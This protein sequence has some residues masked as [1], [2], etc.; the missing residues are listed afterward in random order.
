VYSYLERNRFRHGRLGEPV[1]HRIIL[2]WVLTKGTAKSAHIS[3]HKGNF[4][5]KM[6]PDLSKKVQKFWKLEELLVKRLLSSEE[7]YCK[8]LFEAAHSGDSSEHYIVFR[9]KK[10]CYHI[11]ANHAMMR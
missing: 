3:G 4:H 7:T 10:K 9:Q 2:E 6:E 5:I 8:E 11:W 1:A